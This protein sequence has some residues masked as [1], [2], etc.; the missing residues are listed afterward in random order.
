MTREQFE[1]L[2]KANAEL[3]TQVANLL[4]RLPSAATSEESRQD[5]PA[6]QAVERANDE[7]TVSRLKPQKPQP[8]DPAAKDANLRA[9]L[10]SMNNY[11]QAMGIPGNDDAARVN[12]AVTLLQGAAL[13]WW[14][15]MTRMARG[16]REDAERD[17]VNE[18]RARLFQTPVGEE[19][20]LR[21]AALQQKPETWAQF[22][23]AILARFDLV[24]ASEVARDKL[25]RLRQLT[26][27][28]D[29]TRRFLA[30]CAEIDDLSPAEQAHRYR[31][32]L[33]TDI[34]KALAI[35]GIQDFAT[36]I[37]AAERL[38]SI[39][40]QEKL[41]GFGGRPLGSISAV[42]GEGEKTTPP[43]RNLSNITC[44]RCQQRGHMAR[45][46]KN[47]PK[48]PGERRVSFNEVSGNGTQQ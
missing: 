26:S 22:Q 37:A 2:Q 39:A 33:K 17:D 1:A 23:T 18:V 12:Y 11:F 13:E 40:Y 43:T 10:F 46:C 44:Y 38:D 28:Q 16:R 29:Y 47:K 41:K 31:D 48:Q 19:T 20:R 34:R 6:Q 14:R 4:A 32:G 9:W 5:V 8:Y 25:G 7:R 15:Q 3:A 42:Q 45:N 36:A 30:L 27:V 21:M 35:Q 24:N